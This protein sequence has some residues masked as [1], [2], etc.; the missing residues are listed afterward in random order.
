MNRHIHHVRKSWRGSALGALALVL[1]V[2]IA[3]DATPLAS[4]EARITD[5]SSPGLRIVPAS[6]P[7]DP[8]YGGECTDIQCIL[9][10]PASILVSGEQFTI[11]WLL[12][13]VAN[14]VKALGHYF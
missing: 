6:C 10:P 9:T 5:A 13:R 4:P 12:H 2:L 7:S 8:H 1:V 14:P 11:V 3:M